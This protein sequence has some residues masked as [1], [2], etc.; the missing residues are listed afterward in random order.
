MTSKIRL[1]SSH[2]YAAWSVVVR[3]NGSEALELRMSRKRCEYG[4]LAPHGVEG[5]VVIDCGRL[6]IDEF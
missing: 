1:F 6:S 3:D 2:G 4:P 5:A